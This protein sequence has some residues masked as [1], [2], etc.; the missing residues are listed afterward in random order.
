MAFNAPTHAIIT[1]PDDYIVYDSGI[2]ADSAA[3]WRFLENHPANFIMTPATTVMNLGPAGRYMKNPAVLAQV[4]Y[5]G[6]SESDLSFGSNGFDVLINGSPATI[7]GLVIPQDNGNVTG[8]Y[9]LSALNW[10]KMQLGLTEELKTSVRWWGYRRPSDSLIIR[11][12]QPCDSIYLEVGGSNSIPE[13]ALAGHKYGTGQGSAKFGVLAYQRSNGWDDHYYIGGQWGRLWCMGFKPD[14]EEGKDSI[15]III[16]GTA[17]DWY[18]TQ[19]GGNKSDVRIAPLREMNAD[20]TYVYRHGGMWGQ[21]QGISIN[22]IKIFGGIDKGEI[23]PFDGTV[24]GWTNRYLPKASGTVNLERQLTEADVNSARYAKYAS[25][26]GIVRV[27]LK[28]SNPNG[29]KINYDDRYSNFVLTLDGMTADPVD[30]SG[31][32]IKHSND[33]ASESFHRNYFEMTGKATG[34]QEMKIDFDFVVVD[35][36]PFDFPDSVAVAVKKADAADWVVLG[37]ARNAYSPTTEDPVMSHASFDLPDSIFANGNFA[38]RLLVTYLENSGASLM[39]SNLKVTGFNDWH[40]KD[41]NAPTIAYISN[42]T[43]RIHVLNRASTA[44][45]TDLLLK[46]LIEGTSYNVKLFTQ[47][48]TASLTSPEAVES[49]F[50]DYDMVILSEY[51]GSGDPVVKNLYTLIGKKPFLNLK[52]YAYKNWGLASAWSDGTSDTLGVVESKYSIHPLFNGLTLTEYGEDLLTPSLFVEKDNGTKYLQNVSFNELTGKVI[53][54]G[55]NSNGICIYEDNTVETAKYMLLALSATQNRNLTDEGKTLLDNA[56]AYLIAEGHYE[57]P[58]FGLTSDG[59]LVENTDELAAAMAYDFTVIGIT[60][61]VIEMKTSTD[62]S[63]AYDLSQIQ[64]IGKGSMTIQPHM[65]S[66]VIRM[67]GT[68]SPSVM[69]LNSLTVKNAVFGNNVIPFSFTGRYSLSD[70]FFIDGCTF[71][72]VP[73]ILST[74]GSDSASIAKIS[75]N[76]C[77]IRNVTATLVNV[78]GCLNL[79]A[80]S[81]TENQVLDCQAG[82][83]FSWSGKQL[84]ETSSMTLNHNIFN[85][86]VSASPVLFDF[87]LGN[88]L[89][90]GHLKITNNIFLGMSTSTLS[91]RC[92]MA[93]TSDIVSDH[94][95]FSG[96]LPSWPLADCNDYA[97]AQDQLASQGVLANGAEIGLD[98]TGIVYTAGIDRSYLGAA[99]AYMARTQARNVK[100]SNVPELKTA[101][102]IAIGGDVIELDNYYLNDDD[103]CDVYFLGTSGFDYPRTHGTLTLKAAEG[104]RPK[105]FG[106]ISTAHAARLDTLVYDGLTWV[107]STWFEGYDKEGYNPFFF[108][109]ANDTITGMMIVR[110]C[111]F[112]DQ[113]VQVTLRSRTSA[114]GSYYG[115]VRF[116]NCRFENNGGTLAPGSLGGH[117]VQ[118]D[119]SDT[120]TLNRFEFVNNIVSNFHGSQMF[121]VGRKGAPSPADSVYNIVISHNLFYRIG[122][123]AKDQLRNFLEFNNKISGA[124]VNISIDNNIFYKRWTEEYYPICKVALYTPDSTVTSNIVLSHNF[125]EGKYYTGS[126][127]YTPNPVAQTDSLLNLPVLNGSS[128]DFA[129]YTREAEMFMSTLGIDH[130]FADEAALLISTSSPLYTA[131]TAESPLG[132]DYIYSVIDDLGYNREAARLGLSAYSSDGKVFVS[133]RSNGSAETAA[134]LEVV[135]LV[136]QSLQS[137]DMKGESLMIEGL[138]PGQ[139]YLLRVGNAVQ[140]VLVK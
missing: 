76:N 91:V 113:Q 139:F 46:R 75:V 123:N 10:K 37:Y 80:V 45:S 90:E 61:P 30:G 73:G 96:Q 7:Y 135:N 51:P 89:P 130:V 137:F 48:E 12:K 74:A 49:A 129:N 138:Q 132:P 134:T 5:L 11:V 9:N 77:Q 40:A 56:I 19:T 29:M 125:Y 36:N 116:E 103:S 110:N 107:D 28:S 88:E 47:T 67:A 98:K 86:T 44:D 95:L 120:Y 42:A 18:A 69:N 53:A 85:Q 25:D 114:A 65:A 78:E 81:F 70:G 17:K 8:P 27:M 13:F 4:G 6:V 126:T 24:F 1:D 3:A 23:P 97:V 133:F 112:Y 136:G 140:K 121:N 31:S 105:L 55:V 26:L 102:E 109:S 38:M 79:P 71:D 66:D 14:F 43:D 111:G 108:N 119:A 2:L 106:C 21:F 59:A 83:W 64:T 22:R 62:A 41:E 58:N 33:Y 87:N 94:N 117:L 15:D 16:Q 92:Q 32:A 100:V 50:A 84:A 124:T 34:C 20:S 39:V 128:N 131:G 60:E 82:T 54:R 52:A 104:A 118:F 122:G 127:T 68:F 115:G 72:A 35:G 93:D 99:S 63:G 57:A 101:L